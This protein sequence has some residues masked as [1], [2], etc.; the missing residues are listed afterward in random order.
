MRKKIKNQKVKSKMTNE[1]SKTGGGKFCILIFVFLFGLCS[2]AVV[3]YF[4]PEGRPYEKELYE[5]YNQ[6]ELGMSA[7]GEVLIMIHDP[8]YELLSQ[9]K[10]VV[11]SFGQKKKGYKTW[12]NMVAFDENELTARRKYFFIVDEKSK[13]F[14]FMPKRRLRFESKMIMESEVL[15]EPYANQNARRLAILREVLANLHKDTDE[16]GVD[17]KQLNV[18]RMLINQTLET[19]LQK[20]EESPVLASK[21][22]SAAGVGF[23]HITLGKGSIWMDVDRD[24]VDV[25]VRVDSFADRFEDPFSLRE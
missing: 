17:N 16:V 23:D 3:E 22:S 8:E 5:S 1:N 20:L 6:T 19:I 10:S 11:A 21:L 4:K 9:S 15:D 14:P 2:C 12:F 24:I 7:A 25:K 18:C 13:G